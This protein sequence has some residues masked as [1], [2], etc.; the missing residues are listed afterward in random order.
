M[1]RLTLNEVLAVEGQPC[2][3]CFAI[4]SLRAYRGRLNAKEKEEYSKHL[5][6]EHYMKPY[7]IDK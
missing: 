2:S 5:V 4:V 1:Q 3:F 6:R 7:S